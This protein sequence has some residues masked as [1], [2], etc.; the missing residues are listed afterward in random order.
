MPMDT[1]FWIAVAALIAAIAALAIWR[2]RGLNFELG[3]GGVKVQT[4]ERKE[5]PASRVT[6][7]EHA[8]IGEN[9][10]VGNIIG[11]ESSPGAALANQSVDVA[12]QLEVGKGAKVGNII[13][14]KIAG[15]G[16]PQQ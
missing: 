15:P 8:R 12:K 1:W 13:G 5:D 10:A 3:T 4:Q 16:E 9:A 2:N 11:N 7:A 14:N 6:V